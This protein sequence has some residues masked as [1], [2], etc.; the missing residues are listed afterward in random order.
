MQS[1]ETECKLF[2]SLYL[3]QLPSTHPHHGVHPDAFAFGG[4]GKL[5]DELLELVLQGKKRATT[6]LPIEFTSLGEQ[7]PEVGSVSIIL[8]G[9]L[10][11]VAVIERLSVKAAPFSSVDADYAAIEGEGDGS[12]DSWREAH[13]A[14]FVDVCR[15]LGGEFTESSTVICQTFRLCW[16]R[17]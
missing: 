10:K 5:A 2:W 14:Y 17:R 3:K 6:S 8:D 9:N 13:Q 11:P 1:D 16:P 12:L 15:R 4:E 7:A